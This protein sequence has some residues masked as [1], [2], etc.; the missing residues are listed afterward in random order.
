MGTANMNCTF[1][2]L[3]VDLRTMEDSVPPMHIG[4]P[5]PRLGWRLMSDDIGFCQSAYRVKVFCGDD[6]VWDSQIITGD[7]QRVRCEVAL[8]PQTEYRWEYR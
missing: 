5:H 6:L 3:T 7:T 1:H 8:L 4:T 2:H